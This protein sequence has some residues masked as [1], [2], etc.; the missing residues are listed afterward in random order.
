MVLIICLPTIAQ[1][2]VYLSYALVDKIMVVNFAPH[3]YSGNHVVIVDNLNIAT[4]YNSTIQ[5]TIYG[6]V[7]LLASPAGLL[8]SYAFGRRNKREAQHLIGTSFNIGIILAV[9]VVF[10]GYFML[11]PLINFQAG[12]GQ[13]GGQEAK[14]MAFQ[15][16]RIFLFGFPIAMFSFAITSLMI[17]EGRAV[18]VFVITIVSALL[19]VLFN[20]ILL[21][22]TNL[23]IVGSAIANV[24]IYACTSSLA[25]L[26]LALDK[27]SWIRLHL[28]NMKWDPVLVRRYFSY[29][30]VN[31]V[32]VV[33]GGIPI[34]IMVHLG[35]TA[36]IESFNIGGSTNSP[37]NGIVQ[38]FAANS[39]WYSM[40]RAVVFGMIIGGRSITAY[41]YSGKLYQRMRRFMMIIALFMALWM[42]TAFLIIAAFGQQ[43]IHIFIKDPKLSLHRFHNYLMISSAGIALQCV[44]FISVMFYQ[45]TGQV[46]KALALTSMVA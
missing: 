21:A 23:G 24:L 28:H 13:S 5:A 39:P 38:A 16:S 31:F 22:F 44:I 10:F 3:A 34:M 45:V 40:M 35:S 7:S 18:S 19:N 4:Q 12:F 11:K 8:F 14:N 15:F 33:A 43:L 26:V 25:F 20:W 46:Y 41:C 32:N 27:S 2:V 1:Q 29:G 9:G 42:L 37:T 36:P 6:F 17:A 30:V